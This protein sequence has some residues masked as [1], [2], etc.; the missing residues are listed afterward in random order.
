MAFITEHSNP[1]DQFSPTRCYVCGSPAGKLWNKLTGEAVVRW[2]RKASK[3]QYVCNICVGEGKGIPVA[4]YTK[5][6]RKVMKATKKG[7]L[8]ITKITKKTNGQ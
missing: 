2:F 6:E 3:G 5:K 8:G 4:K 7:W 1:N